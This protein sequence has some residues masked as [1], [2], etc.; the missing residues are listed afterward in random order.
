MNVGVDEDRDNFEFF[1]TLTGK[2]KKED[3][4]LGIM[5]VCAPY[6]TLIKYKYKVK[7]VPGNTKRG[8]CLRFIM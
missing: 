5:A 1:D 7:L 8:K 6:P 3:K 2:P 4:I